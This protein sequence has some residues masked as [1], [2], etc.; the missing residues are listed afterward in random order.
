MPPLRDAIQNFRE[1]R[2]RI[3]QGSGT[4]NPYVGN[5]GPT[6]TLGTPRAQATPQLIPPAYTPPT[7]FQQGPTGWF[8]ERGRYLQQWDGIWWW[9]D[10]FDRTWWWRDQN[11]YLHRQDGGRVIW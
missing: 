7:N 1:N 2:P 10:Q 5:W 9:Q 6:I 3:L 8:L 4:F 11:G